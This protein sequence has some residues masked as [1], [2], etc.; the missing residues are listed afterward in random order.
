MRRCAICGI[1]IDVK[2]EDSVPT[3][4]G[5]WV[6]VM[7]ADN[8][9]SLAWAQRRRRVLLHGAVLAAAIIL[10][11]RLYLDLWYTAPSG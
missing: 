1:T 8:E 5:A 7:C 11:N 9:A 3:L 4:D 6:H 2:V 10:F